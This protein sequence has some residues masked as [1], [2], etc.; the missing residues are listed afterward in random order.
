MS[1]AIDNDLL[2]KTVAED[3][4]GAGLRCKSILWLSIFQ[5]S[6]LIVESTF[7]LA[8]GDVCT[9]QVKEFTSNSAN[10]AVFEFAVLSPAVGVRCED[11][12][13]KSASNE[14]A[15]VKDT[16]AEVCFFGEALDSIYAV[17]S[18]VFAVST[19]IEV[20]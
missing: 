6:I 14:F 17:E 13:D 11:T 18:T 3:F 8:V 4:E 16:V 15:V 9:V 5:A 7:D 12:I 20:A 1:E 10:P 19:V 2:E